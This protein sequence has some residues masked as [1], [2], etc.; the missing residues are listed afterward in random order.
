MVGDDGFLDFAVAVARGFDGN[1]YFI[2]AADFAVPKV[3]AGD[4]FVLHAGGEVFFQKQTADFLG[5]FAGR[6]GGGN[7]DGFECGHFNS[8]VARYFIHRPVAL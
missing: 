2:V 6:G 7:D 4:G 5:F 8:T 1:A 3:L